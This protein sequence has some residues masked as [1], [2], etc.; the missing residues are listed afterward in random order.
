M[1][2]I[3]NDQQMQ[4]AASYRTLHTF[5]AQGGEG[6]GA[7]WGEPHR[8]RTRLRTGSKEPEKVKGPEGRK[9]YRDKGNK[10]KGQPFSLDEG[11][12]CNDSEI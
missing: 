10:K 3:L 7:V 9:Q 1:N 4:G 6:R 11:F 8:P 12:L 5:H 2:G